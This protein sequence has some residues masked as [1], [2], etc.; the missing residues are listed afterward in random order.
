MF[1]AVGPDFIQHYNTKF[2]LDNPWG[3]EWEEQS[4]AYL[5]YLMVVQ[6]Y[7]TYHPKFDRAFPPELQEDCVDRI[8]LNV[9]TP[10]LLLDPLTQWPDNINVSGHLTPVQPPAGPGWRRIPVHDRRQIRQVARDQS[11]LLTAHSIDMD[12]TNYAKVV[13]VKFKLQIRW[14]LYNPCCPR[15]WGC[16]SWM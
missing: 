5:H 4:L 10:N 13:T 14:T 9:A 8:C 15:C 7:N 1:H 2:G 12:Q 16:Q 11:R 6:S 3:Q